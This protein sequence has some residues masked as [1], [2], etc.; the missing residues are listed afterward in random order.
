MGG[1]DV[2][3]TNVIGTARVHLAIEH[4][5]SIEDFVVE[6]FLKSGVGAFGACKNHLGPD[7]V[8]LDAF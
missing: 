6:R 3:F 1:K 5:G 4:E 7:A 8:T 2:F